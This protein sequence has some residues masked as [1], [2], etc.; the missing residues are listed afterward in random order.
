MPSFRIKEKERAP[1][2][3]EKDGLAI[4][5]RKSLKRSANCGTKEKAWRR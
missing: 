4:R 2:L 3:G 1:C 5:E